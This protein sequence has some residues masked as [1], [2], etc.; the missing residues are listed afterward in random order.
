MSDTRPG[1]VPPAT[2]DGYVLVYITAPGPKEATEI[3]R[4]LVA[5]R[6]AACCNVIPSIRSVYWWEGKMA[7]E[8]ES[9]ILAKTRSQLL[10]DLTRRVKEIHPYTVPAVL[11]VPVKGGNPEFLAWVSSETQPQP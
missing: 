5:R 9:A 8:D 3:A 7:E 11:G 6:L 4:D 1:A 2:S 10:E